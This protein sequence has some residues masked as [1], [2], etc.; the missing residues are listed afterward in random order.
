MSEKQTL[1]RWLRTTAVYHADDAPQTNS[2]WRAAL[3]VDFEHDTPPERNS[4]KLNTRAPLQFHHLVLMAPAAVVIF[5][6]GWLFGSGTTV[7]DQISRVSPIVWTACAVVGAA[8]FLA[9]RSPV[10]GGR[11]W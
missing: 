1:S 6:L 5:W 9:W 3:L 8:G 4:A 2:D 11:R 7:A 10:L